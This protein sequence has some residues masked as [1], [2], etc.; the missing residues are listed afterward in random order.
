MHRVQP[1]ILTDL[2]ARVLQRHGI[3]TD[4][5]A[6]VA[7]TLVES[8]LRGIHS[9]GSMRLGRYVRELET[10]ITTPS[11]AIRTVAEGP[12]FARVDGGG[13][14]GQLVGRH[15]LSV[16]IHKARTAGSASVT[17]CHS[18]HFG[19]AGTYC[20]MAIRRDMVAVAMTVSS[21]RM[22]PTG[23]TKPLFGTN[24]VALG[25]PGD[26]DFPLI[27]DLAMSSIAAGNLE[28]AAAGGRQLAP[29]VAR[30]LSGNGTTDPAVALRGSI[31][32][33]GEHKGYALTMLIEILAGCLQAPPTLP[34]NAMRS[35]TMSWRKASGT[36]S[37]ASIRLASCR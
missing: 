31:V 19:A 32:P 4:D 5:A 34:S 25:V 8:D 37:C 23:G 33:I 36:S 2:C 1:A 7:A 16:C 24:P 13:G 28:L 29:G 17:A 10:G 14:L 22:A 27:I 15:A 3:A 20:L 18:R 6:F 12:S 9:H 21:P 11:P 30:D 26:Q 35:A